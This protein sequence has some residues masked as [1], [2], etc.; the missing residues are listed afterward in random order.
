MTRTPGRRL[1]AHIVSRIF[2]YVSCDCRFPFDAYFWDY[3]PSDHVCCL[4]TPMSLAD[5]LSSGHEAPTCEWQRTIMSIGTDLSRECLPYMHLR[6]R[7]S[8]ASYP[9]D[10]R[11][12]V[13]LVGQSGRSLKHASLRLRDNKEVVMTAVEMC[14]RSLRFASLRLRDDKDVVL[15]ATTSWSY[16]LRYASFRL[17]NDKDVVLAAT[18]Y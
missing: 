14:G 3:D 15:A 1:P 7:H 16:A 10:K 13:V 8:M 2:G 6:C 5:Y 12:V 9:D 17:C 4:P 18:Y 11:T